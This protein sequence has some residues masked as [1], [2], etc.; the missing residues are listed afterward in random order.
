M[1]ALH[2]ALIAGILLIVSGTISVALLSTLQLDK[3]LETMTYDKEYTL[4]L[5]NIS[6]LE[7]DLVSTDITMTTQGNLAT[8]SHK[9]TCTYGT[10]SKKELP[11]KEF[12]VDVKTNKVYAYM[13][14]HE[15]NFKQFTYFTDCDDQV[16]ITIPQ[17][18]QGDLKLYGV[19]T[20]VFLKDI[21]FQE[22]DITT[23]SGDIDMSGTIQKA[24]V[25]SVSGDI[26]FDRVGELT[27]TST[28]GDILVNHLQKGRIDTVSGDVTLGVD[29]NTTVT[30][31]SVS[32]SLYGISN[33]G[34]LSD[35]DI[36]TVSGDAV[37]NIIE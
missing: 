11:Q 21:N 4:S 26:D 24:Y 15:W 37:I 19:S 35:I 30:F 36:Q 25:D 23:V 18:F 33:G 9:G 2:I 31:D 1:K 17:T 32:G 3:N 13:N 5:E 27:V 34:R 28:S 22:V 8:F 10:L 20:D 29:N 16:S 7:I 12:I 6:E 14:H